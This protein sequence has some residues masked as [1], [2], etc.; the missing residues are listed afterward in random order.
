MTVATVNTLTGSKNLCV[1]VNFDLI[2]FRNF[3]SLNRERLHWKMRII[4][5]Y[6]R[7]NLFHCLE[8]W[9]M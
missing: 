7:A 9:Y 8:Y 5:L 4:L 1:T 3:N 2:S 6:D